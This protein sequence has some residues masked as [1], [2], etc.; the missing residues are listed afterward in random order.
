MLL[1]QRDLEVVSEAL[2]I[3]LNEYH[4]DIKHGDMTEEEAGPQIAALGEIAQR[5][6]ARAYPQDAHIALPRATSRYLTL[7]HATSP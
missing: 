7:P 4:Q 6:W 2:A 1:S 5:F 3:A